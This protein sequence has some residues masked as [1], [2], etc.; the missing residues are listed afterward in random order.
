[1]FKRDLKN[2]FK[3]KLLR[4]KTVVN[5]LKTLI[6]Q[7]VDLID[8]LYER[9]IKKRCVNVRNRKDFYI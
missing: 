7:A 3:N 8:K 4:N 9:V 6:E 5:N 2:N 1:M